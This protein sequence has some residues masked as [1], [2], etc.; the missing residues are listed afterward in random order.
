M[1]HSD[2]CEGIA[3][4]GLQYSLT[5][6]CCKFTY[7]VCSVTSLF[8]QTLYTYPESFRGNKVLIAAQYSGAEL[9]VVSEAPE[10]QLGKTNKT[11]EFLTKF[12]LGKVGIN[13]RSI[14]KFG[15][16]YWSS[17]KYIL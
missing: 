5:I 13:S 9:K 10:F 3:E 11:E 12:P 1:I 17:R 15:S 8:L 7:A 14:F 4:G 2:D 16:R 6:H